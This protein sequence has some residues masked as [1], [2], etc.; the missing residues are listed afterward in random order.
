[1]ATEVRRDEAV[2]MI[3]AVRF[4]HDETG[5]FVNTLDDDGVLPQ[6]GSRAAWEQTEVN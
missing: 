3:E 5:R 2:R 4:L 1:M 6:E